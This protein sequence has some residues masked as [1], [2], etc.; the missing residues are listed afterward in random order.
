LRLLCATVVAAALWTACGW[1]PADEQ[2]LVKFFEQSRA[3]DRTRLA[4]IATVVFDPRTDGVVERFDVV[5]R[6]A[7]R[8]LDDG[9]LAKEVT[10]DATVRSAAGRLSQRTLIVTFEQRDGAWIVTRFR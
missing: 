7:E 3:Y 10:V 9:R 6:G 5:A 2:Q 1:A 8:R 4:P